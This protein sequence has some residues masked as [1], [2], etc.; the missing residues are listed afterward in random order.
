MKVLISE[1]TLK[2]MEVMQIPDFPFTEST[3]QTSKKALVIQYHP[4]RNKDPE[5]S[6][7]MKE[8]NCVFDLLE[9]LALPEITD[10]KSR[11]LKQVYEVEK[12]DIFTIWESCM[13]CNQ[14][15]KIVLNKGT[16]KQP[17]YIV[18]ICHECGGV[19]KI[20]LNLF[21]PIIP[22]GAILK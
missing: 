11:I 21:N 15:G 14:T 6:E 4:D 3:L 16:H 8:I 2:A 1:N 12:E 7:K 13:R 17:K 9:P 22:K 19:T 18:N 20:K 10:E 5:A